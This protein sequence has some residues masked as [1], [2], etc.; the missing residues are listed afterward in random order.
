MHKHYKK[1]STGQ[2]LP[3]LITVNIPIATQVFFAIQILSKGVISIPLRM[4]P[5]FRK[6]NKIFMGL[7]G[8]DLNTQPVAEG[9]LENRSSKFWSK[10]I[11][12]GSEKWCLILL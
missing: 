7:E 2:C 1:S 8:M 4:L 12:Y 9:D 3:H 6:P 11:K 10:Y 5:Q